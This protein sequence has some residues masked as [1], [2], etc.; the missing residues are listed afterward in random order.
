MKG[1]ARAAQFFWRI[2]NPYVG[3]YHLTSSDKIRH[4]NS[5]GGSATLSTQ[6]VEP[7]HCWKFLWPLASSYAHTVWCKRDKILHVR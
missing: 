5:C 7:Q 4:A 1:G 2:S 3:S 6:V